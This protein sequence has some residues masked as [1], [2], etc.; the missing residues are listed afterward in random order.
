MEGLTDNILLVLLVLIIQ[1]SFISAEE[2]VERYKIEGKVSIQGH[3]NSGKFLQDFLTLS[4]KCHYYC[5]YIK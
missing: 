1:I 5:F 2:Q 3:K 4:N